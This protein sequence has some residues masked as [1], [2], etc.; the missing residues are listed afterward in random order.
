VEDGRY[1]YL[2]ALAALAADRL[3]LSPEALARE[4]AEEEAARADPW[5]WYCRLCGATGE[6]DTA[7][8]QVRSA[9]AHL[10]ETP[11]G[12]HGVRREEKWGRLIHVWSYPV[13]AVAR[14]N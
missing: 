4:L 9:R 8:E 14:L 10:T 7:E 13:S 6:E 1:P 5:R 12:R 2:S 11:C 3:G